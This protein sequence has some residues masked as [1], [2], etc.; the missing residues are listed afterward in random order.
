MVFLKEFSEKVDFEQNQ[1]MTK[2][3]EKLLSRPRV[4]QNDIGECF[5]D[6]SWIQD[7]EGDYPQK[8]SLEMLN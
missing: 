6:Y 3:H 4:N 2:K 7:F 8:L 5:Q 1:Q